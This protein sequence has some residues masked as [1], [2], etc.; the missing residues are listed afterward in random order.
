MLHDFTGLF[1]RENLSR[2]FV[3][4][5]RASDETFILLTSML[6][7]R[8]NQSTRLHACTLTRLHAYTLTRLH[9]RTHLDILL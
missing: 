8:S 9:A 2:L 1:L 4:R 6:S 7:I 5:L 3:Q